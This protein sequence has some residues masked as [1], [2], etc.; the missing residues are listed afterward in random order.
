MPYYHRTTELSSVW[1]LSCGLKRSRYKCHEIKTQEIDKFFGPA[2][3]FFILLTSHESENVNS[4]SVVSKLTE[5]LLL[6]VTLNTQLLSPLRD[7][8]LI[9]VFSKS[10]P[11]PD[12]LSQNDFP[13]TWDYF[14]RWHR[15][16]ID[17]R[18]L[19]RSATV[20]CFWGCTTKFSFF[21]G[22]RI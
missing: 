8:E 18:V 1:S 21:R 5:Q 17:P 3:I 7:Q 12:Q 13:A 15:Q 9:C 2:N 4:G 10:V 19:L 11:K 6:K 22:P 20:A 16:Q 14:Y